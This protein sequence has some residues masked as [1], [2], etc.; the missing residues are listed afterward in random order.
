MEHCIAPNHRIELN[1]HIKRGHNCGSSVLLKITFSNQ[2][3]T[4]HT[5]AA[6]GMG[7]DKGTPSCASSVTGRLLFT[8]C[9][10]FLPSPTPGQQPGSPAWR[11]GAE[12]SLGSPPIKPELCQ[13]LL[14]MLIQSIA[15]I[16]KGVRKMSF[17]GFNI[18][19]N[20]GIHNVSY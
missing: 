11:T 10:T 7:R 9:C 6:P 19:N 15:S 12:N 20:I 16:R 4:F 5:L 2:S 18:L 13:K 3:E 1:Q 8:R 17:V 14:C